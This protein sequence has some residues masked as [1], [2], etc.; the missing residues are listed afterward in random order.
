MTDHFFTVANS[1]DQ[2]LDDFEEQ[3]NNN[4]PTKTLVKQ[5]ITQSPT[6]NSTSSK[7]IL[8]KNNIEG[9]TQPYLSYDESFSSQSSEPSSFED[10]YLVD[11]DDDDENIN[12][13]LNLSYLKSLQA[14][15]GSPITE[16]VSAINS[17][18]F[19]K[20]GDDSKNKTFSTPSCS[21]N[22]L[23][24]N[25]QTF[26]KSNTICFADKNPSQSEESNHKLKDYENSK[27][28]FIVNEIIQDSISNQV[29]SCDNKQCSSQVK[30]LE[31][32]C[33][34]E[35][36][37]N[38]PQL[39]IKKSL[40]SYS[41]IEKKYI[42][43]LSLE[44][45]HIESNSN[46][47]KDLIDEVIT[48][49][50]LNNSDSSGGLLDKHY[51]QKSIIKDTLS[52]ELIVDNFPKNLPKEDSQ[53]FEDTLKS[54]KLVKLNI[55]KSKNLKID[56]HIETSTTCLN[57][58][59]INVSKIMSTSSYD[60]IANDNPSL[61]CQ[62][63]TSSENHS[64]S[65]KQQSDK[66]LD[67]DENLSDENIIPPISNS[68]NY[69]PKNFKNVV[70][71]QSSNDLDNSKLDTETNNSQCEN[72]DEQADE[73][74]NKNMFSKS[75]HS[76]ETSVGTNIPETSH[77]GENSLEKVESI[78]AITQI[79]CPG[80]TKPIWVPDTEVT[81]CSNCQDKFTFT[82][83][84]HHCRACGKIFCSSCC[85][86][87][88]KLQYLQFEE[89]RVCLHCKY[90]IEKADE[91][92]KRRLLK[93]TVLT[94]QT[95]SEPQSI[96]TPPNS[97]SGG[98]KVRFSDGTR[99]DHPQNTPNTPPLPTKIM[100][101][102]SLRKKHTGL[103]PIVKSVVERKVTSVFNP[104][105]MQQVYTIMTSIKQPSIVF[106]LSPNLY[107]SY[108][109]V[110]YRGNMAYYFLSRGLVN[111]GQ[112]EA[113]LLI[114]IA[115]SANQLSELDVLQVCKMYAHMFNQS[116]K[117]KYINPMNF[118]TTDS[119]LEDTYF[120]GNESY[121]G[122]LFTK[123]SATHDLSSLQ[124]PD[125][126][127]NELMTSQCNKFSSTLFGLVIHRSELGL[128]R[129]FPTRL[130]VS[131]GLQQNEHPYTIVNNRKRSLVS[132]SCEDSVLRYLCDLN[133]FNYGITTLQGIKI[134]IHDFHLKVDI[135]IN[136]LADLNEQILK[137]SNE[138][139]I[140]IGSDQ[141]YSSYANDSC[142]YLAC[143]DK[144]KTHVMATGEN[145]VTNKIL[146]SFIILSGSLRAGGDKKVNITIVEDGVMV[147]LMTESLDN[148]R[149]QILAGKCFTIEN[150]TKSNEDLY[151]F[152]ISVQHN[153]DDFNVG[154]YSDVDL[155]SLQGV[156]G[157]NVNRSEKKTKSYVLRWNQVFC[158]QCE[159]EGADKSVCADV[160]G[161]TVL[162]AI[163]PHLHKLI[164]QKQ[165][166][167]AIRAD[168]H[169]ERVGFQAGCEGLPLPDSC[170]NSLDSHLIPLLTSS[171]SLGSMQVEDEVLTFEMTFSV[172]QVSAD[173][174]YEAPPNDE[175]L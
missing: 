107:V 139:L 123:T 110:Q 156:I 83:R 94:Q 41:N 155:S 75:N 29:V 58:Q 35:I 111:V 116:R 74:N 157:Y 102:T 103:P 6:Q 112:S 136:R 143:N 63:G 78:N 99:P 32:S 120:L 14:I 104:I 166:R 40:D 144:A 71:Q 145:L 85:N 147:E 73:V 49:K 42:E 46:E 141:M 13:T 109:I 87:K 67:E 95:T 18:T 26:N 159:I 127:L 134:E 15:K 142:M 34:N 61:V 133:D 19:E 96:L 86:F 81:N 28:N 27:D 72:V 165:R 118:L 22:K 148:L 65:T 8:K 2:M 11:D 105:S 91:E 44:K 164:E 171:S 117:G 175:V 77:V 54:N 57:N 129:V 161:N 167:F 132:S 152:Q 5:N 16:L 60:E 98:K 79:P 135:P 50:I 59:L 100:E 113:A 48:S 131:L 126:E 124:S 9:K 160:I 172:L 169:P 108:R 39:E 52:A 170:L 121:A 45:Y 173:W 115:E 56:D 137:S 84:R 62:E 12:K 158:Y 119:F 53:S 153:D 23:D 24:E 4:Q 33:P 30:D 25:L 43:D 1:L 90:A 149:N 69:E 162:V 93:P 10:E 151:S 47:T 140:V 51:L 150:N 21:S 130:L 168:I 17:V 68:T 76:I 101:R 3:E 38:S 106:A 128:L 66:T 122:I 82:R 20:H 88:S 114:Q 37:S 7:L 146:P 31:V 125:D 154:M 97:S 80:T 92:L 89:A 55:K 138:H 174:E 70:E 36:K 163:A 64:N